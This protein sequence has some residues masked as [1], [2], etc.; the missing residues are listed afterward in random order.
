MLILSLG[1]VKSYTILGFIMQFS[2]DLKLF[3][4]LKSLYCALVQYSNMDSLES[5][6]GRR[7]KPT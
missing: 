4:A 2:K 6:Y 1:V 7:F 3:R 5:L